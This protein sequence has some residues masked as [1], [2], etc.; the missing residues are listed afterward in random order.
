[1]EMPR[2]EWAGEIFADDGRWIGTLSC[3]TGAEMLEALHHATFA[4]H[5]V[6][7]VHRRPVRPATGLVIDARGSA[8]LAI[9]RRHF[10]LL[11]AEA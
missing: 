10:E 9:A 1:M 7:G 2:E 8:G 5:R 4:G 6:S 11:Q 3:D